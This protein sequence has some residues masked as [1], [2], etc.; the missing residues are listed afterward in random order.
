MAA[1]TA[2]V[3][4]RVEVVFEVA[5]PLAEAANAAAEFAALVVE[6]LAVRPAVAVAAGEAEV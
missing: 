6:L 5:V 4:R 3:A 1:A 2:L